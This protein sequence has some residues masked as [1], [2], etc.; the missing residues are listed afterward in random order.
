MGRRMKGCSECDTGLL[1]HEGEESACLERGEACLRGRDMRGEV[2]G[3]AAGD[4]AKDWG[5]GTRPRFRHQGLGGSSRQGAIF[6]ACVF[7]AATLPG[8]STFLVMPGRHPSVLRQCLTASATSPWGQKG[9]NGGFA[10]GPRTHQ[11]AS[12]AR[13]QP[14]SSG[15]RKL[16]GNIDVGKGGSPKATPTSVVADQAGGGTK[17]GGPAEVAGG[18]DGDASRLGAWPRSKHF[19]PPIHVK[20]ERE[21]ADNAQLGTRSRVFVN[22]TECSARLESGA[23][24]LKEGYQPGDDLHFTM[25][26]EFYSERPGY[27]HMHPPLVEGDAPRLWITDFG[28][29]GSG[30]VIGIDVS[31]ERQ[32]SVCSAQ[33][34]WPNAVEFVPANTWEG[35]AKP[36]ILVADGFL[37]PGKTNGAVF[38][39]TEPG[40]ERE[41]VSKL[42]SDK[43]QFFYHK[44]IPLEINGRQGVLTARACKPVLPWLSAQGEL[45]WLEK[46]NT[47]APTAT[48]STPWREVVLAKGPDVMFDVV[49]L[50]PNDGTVEVFAAE[51]F[52]RKLTMMSLEWNDQASAPRV[53]EREVIDSNLGQ[54]YSVQ[55]V[56]LN[57][58]N[59][60]ILVTTHEDTPPEEEEGGA[61]PFLKMSSINTKW[62]YTKTPSSLP[63]DSRSLHDQASSFPFGASQ[64]GGMMLAYK[65]PASWR[66]RRSLQTEVGFLAGLA[67]LFSRVS[68]GEGRV[69][70]NEF[71][72]ALADSG[73]ELNPAEVY[74][75]IFN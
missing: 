75:Y 28:M 46:P 43:N 5:P 34:P 47:L 19:F 33:M 9:F 18:G 51:F 52:A 30:G 61:K 25:L 68:S 62:T 50:D 20:I 6:L 24:P 57:G 56:D 36:G 45:V 4:A 63:K 74:I 27:L 38:C 53:K 59:S 14:L 71:D 72:K 37:V 70:E 29:V 13:R 58:P 41:Q 39:V 23:V 17:G 35:L 60:H 11:A 15:L 31:G 12:G 32:A 10:G 1:A 67:G 73:L 40:T 44:A 64:T 8:Y 54:A 21:L 49:D 48:W 22:D 42:T 26:G 55:V 3:A 7:L 66:S 65:I 2:Y 16:R 69:S